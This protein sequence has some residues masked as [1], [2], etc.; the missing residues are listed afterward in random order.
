M[1]YSKSNSRSRKERAHTTLDIAAFAQSLLAHFDAN[2][3]D[4]PWRETRDP[5]RIWV[6]EIMLQQ[7][8]VETVRPYYKR[9]L[10]LFPDVHVL[11][12]APVDSVLKAW[13]GLGYY[14]R[15][16]NLHRGARVVREQYHGLLPRSPELLRELPGI[17]EYTAGAIASIAYGVP[18]PA[19]DG[20]TKRV[21]CRLLDAARLS[22]AELRKHANRL[23]P[24]DRPG[25]FNQAMM[26]LGATICTPK[27]PD[28]Q[29]CPVRSHCRAF[30]RGTQQ[31]R[32]ATARAKP[33]PDR[34]FVVLVLLDPHKLVLLRQRPERGLLAGLWEF[35]TFEAKRPRQFL[36][37]LH[38]PTTLRSRKLAT[39]IHPFSHFR[40]HYAIH[41]YSVA[42]LT[43]PDDQ[44]RVV[45]W[46]DLPTFALPAAQLEVRRRVS[47][48]D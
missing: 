30:S 39:L 20:N 36:A 12:A 5:Y 21:L 24:P 45:A 26:E 9:W 6:S 35:P 32:P 41:L 40:A 33:V 19:V 46:D 28:C 8:R 27:K 22:P 15:A 34:D 2:Q 11:A 42:T 18:A 4:L 47:T 7:T 10:Q 14:S 48:V 43:P 37:A 38:Q 13:E 17:G 31:R 25:D 3:R 1:P 29:R 16:H 23:I 44:H